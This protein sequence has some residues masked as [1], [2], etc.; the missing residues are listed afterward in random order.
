M[1]IDKYFNV[2]NRVTF[3]SPDVGLE[4]TTTRLKGVRSTD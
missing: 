3:L 1:K 4:P 2:L